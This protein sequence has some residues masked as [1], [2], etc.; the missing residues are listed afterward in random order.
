MSHTFTLSGRSSELRTDFNPPL[1]L[2][3]ESDYQLCLLNFDTFNSIPNVDETNN[4][5]HYRVNR[6]PRREVIIPTGTYDIN[7]INSYL[8]D[9][10]EL[11]DAYVQIRPNNNTLKTEIKTQ[12]E[13]DFTKGNSI[14]RLLG[15]KK[16]LLLANRTHESDYP[17]DISKVNAI[18]IE[19]NLVGGSYNNGVP[20]HIIHQFFPNVPPGYKIIESPQTVIYLPTPA[21]VITNIIVKITD[22]D[23]GLINFREELVTVRLHLRKL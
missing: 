12:A 10:L 14:G 20:V 21:K 3:E 23:G 8:K 4:T 17:T 2:D 7:D 22:Q 13:V 5:F 16:R 6:G 18:C 19:C 9:V 15:F 1:Y 11:D